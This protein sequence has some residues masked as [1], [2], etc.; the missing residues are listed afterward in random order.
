MGARE[1][2]NEEARE[3]RE[4]GDDGAGVL[5][6]AMAGDMY[7]RKPATDDARERESMTGEPPL[8]LPPDCEGGSVVVVGGEA[9]ELDEAVAMANEEL[10]SHATS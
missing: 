4:R 6:D 8:P 2:R 1:A 10:S 9:E 5:A 3:M 7:G